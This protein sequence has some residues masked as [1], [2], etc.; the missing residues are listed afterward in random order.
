MAETIESL[1]KQIREL[2][3]RIGI[4]EDDPAKE[5]YIVLVDILRQQN[6]YLKNIKINDLLTSSEEKG[7]AS[8]YERAKALWE[9][10]SKMISSVSALRLELKMDGE[11]NKSTYKPITAKE[12]ANGVQSY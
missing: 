5:G 4:G 11:Q 9:G 7:K 10:L 3:S 2:E 8:E 1:K 6:K 12:I